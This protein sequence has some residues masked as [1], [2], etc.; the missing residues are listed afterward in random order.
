MHTFGERWREAC[1]DAILQI[2]EER[3]EAVAQL[4]SS[5]LHA[6]ET[7]STGRLFDGIAA[8]CGLFLEARFEAQA[9]MGLEMAARKGFD[10]EESWSVELETTNGTLRI[11]PSVFVRPLIEN[12]S[13]GVPVP[14]VAMRFHRTLA[15][16]LR[17]ACV[18]VRE[19]TGLSTVVAS[20]GVLQNHVLATL[21]SHALQT[22]GFEV[23]LHERVPPNDGGI[24]LGQVAVARARDSSPSS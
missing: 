2:P 11:D 21:L 16:A 5:G 23:L 22:E 6:P 18:V 19:R 14:V 9:A 10:D 7:S 4:V 17:A 8:L 24:A 1:P 3:R 15:Q 12:L 13:R 20:G